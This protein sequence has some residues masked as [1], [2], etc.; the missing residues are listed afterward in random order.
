MPPP[1]PPPWR[2][3]PSGG[4]WRLTS[5]TADSRPGARPQAD[6]LV[7]RFDDT[8]RRGDA[9]RFVGLGALMGR[10]TS[11]A[12]TAAVRRNGRKGGRPLKAAHAR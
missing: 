6:V 11:A 5:G 7:L 9:L 3:G 8:A 12:K 4:R 1:I 2:S 10:A